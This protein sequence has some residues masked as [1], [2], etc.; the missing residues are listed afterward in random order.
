MYDGH[1]VDRWVA[2]HFSPFKEQTHDAQAFEHVPYELLRHE[3]HFAKLPAL[4][5]IISKVIQITERTE[6]VKISSASYKLLHPPMCSL[7]MAE[8]IA[9]TKR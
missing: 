7:W 9:S 8:K 5:V 6:P 4:F 2:L 3:F 1:P